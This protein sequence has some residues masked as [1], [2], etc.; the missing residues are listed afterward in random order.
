MPRGVSKLGV[1]GVLV[2]VL[3]A[4]AGGWYAATRWGITSTKEAREQC[5]REG[6]R[7]LTLRGVVGDSL[8]VPLTDYGLYK[9]LD[10]DGHLWVLSRRGTP[11]KGSKVKVKGRLFATQDLAGTCGS[12]GISAEVCRA[13]SGLLRAASGACLL[14]E[15][16]RN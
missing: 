7:S 8:G 3:L 9:V 15:D 11:D 14:L 4:A 2:L 16:G 5:S 6:E 12:E 13:V 1:L 10:D